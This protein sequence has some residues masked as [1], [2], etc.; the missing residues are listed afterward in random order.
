MATGI[1]DVIPTPS[2]SAGVSDG[3]STVMIPTAF[4]G[5]SMRCTIGTSI[6]LE[7]KTGTVTAA[8][9]SRWNLARKPQLVVM[10]CTPSRSRNLAPSMKAG[11]SS[12]AP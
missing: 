4:P 7:V 6:R 11:N 3:A 9:M 12:L 8:A 5:G 1:A 10:A 2:K